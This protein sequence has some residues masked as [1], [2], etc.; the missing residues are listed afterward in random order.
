M[1]TPDYSNRLMATT[2]DCGCSQYA[3]SQ[4]VRSSD[5]KSVRGTARGADDEYE[6]SKPIPMTIGDAISAALTQKSYRHDRDASDKTG[7]STHKGRSKSRPDVESHVGGHISCLT[8][9]VKKE[10]DELQIS[11]SVHDDYIKVA[12]MVDSGATETIPCWV[13]TV[14]PEHMLSIKRSAGFEERDDG[15]AW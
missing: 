6:G 9:G 5:S 3:G 2:W 8:G 11:T 4:L 12:V 10:P 14:C 15:K 7:K 13:C 1:T